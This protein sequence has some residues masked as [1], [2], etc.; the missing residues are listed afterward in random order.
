V[1]EVAREAVEERARAAVAVQPVPEE[2]KA[3][4]AA[5]AVA[6]GEAEAP[7]GQAEEAVAA[8][9]GTSSCSPRHP[10]S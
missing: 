7:V 6:A 1:L 4:V 2:A 10:P 9:E 3:E 5:A 8:P